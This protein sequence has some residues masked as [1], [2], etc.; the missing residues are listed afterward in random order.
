M[1]HLQLVDGENVKNCLFLPD[2]QPLWQL[3][4]YFSVAQA[5]SAQGTR[6]QDV[7]ERVCYS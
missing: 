7:D 2:A 4:S 5:G 1:S 3:V 6:M